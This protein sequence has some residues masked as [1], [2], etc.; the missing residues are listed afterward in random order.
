M[1]WKVRRA[2]TKTLQ[3]LI[4]TCSTEQFSENF[5]RI[6]AVLLKKINAREQNIRV[7]IFRAFLLI[8]DRLG[9]FSKHNMDID[10]KFTNDSTKRRKLGESTNPFFQFIEFENSFLNHLIASLLKPCSIEQALLGYRIII[11]TVGEL[12]RELSSSQ[13]KKLLSGLG[14]ILGSTRAGGRRELLRSEVTSSNLL[15]LECLELI[16]VIMI[17]HFLTE[18]TAAK[19]T[20]SVL[21]SMNDKFFKISVQ[22]LKLCPELSIKAKMRSEAIYAAVESFVKGSQNDVDAKSAAVEALGQVAVP[23]GK[24]N[25]ALEVLLSCTRTEYLLLPTI[26]AMA[27][28]LSQFTP[29]PDLVERIVSV[30]VALLKS[31]RRNVKIAVLECLEKA[32]ALTSSQQQLSVLRLLPNLL[33]EE[34]VDFQGLSSV[35]SIA[36]VASAFDDQS[37][38]KARLIEIAANKQLPGFVVA[39]LQTFFAQTVAKTPEQFPGLFKQIWTLM[40]N[41]KAEHSTLAK[42]LASS[43]VNASLDDQ[44]NCLDYLCSKV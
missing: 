4:R 39:K 42:C 11:H 25:E 15:K 21:K 8:C 43:L 26:R 10:G 7:E 13:L 14:D 34:E 5:G 27:S 36:T 40:L 32:V 37:L 31:T 22:A 12:Q 29:M 28:I 6:F 38:L 24:G 20:D 35:L 17:T 9:P 33:D 41:R 16:R 23:S 3:I 44:G 18:D 30:L 19:F 2:A 1:S